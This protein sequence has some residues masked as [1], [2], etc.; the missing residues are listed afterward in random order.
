[1]DLTVD[2][3]QKSRGARQPEIA[4]H[5]ADV[6]PQGGTDGF[7][8]MRIDDGFQRRLET[9]PVPF[10]KPFFRVPD[11]AETFREC[12]RARWENTTPTSNE[13][14]AR[15]FAPCTPVQAVSPTA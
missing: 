11:A 10:A 12:C 8:R 1:M 5:N 7:Q 2:D 9:E 15:R 6:M 4:A 14:L 13:L 3:V